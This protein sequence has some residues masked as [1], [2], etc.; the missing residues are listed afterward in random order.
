MI[1]FNE[2]IK[3]LALLLF[4]TIS[5]SCSCSKDKEIGEDDPIA[6]EEIK[7]TGVYTS[8]KTQNVNVVYFYP[9]GTT[10]LPNY[11][12]RLSGIMDYIQG[13]LADELENYGFERKEFGLQRDTGDNSL[14]KIIPIEGNETDYTNAYSKTRQEV[15]NYFDAH[16]EEESSS[17]TV[18][19][20][21]S[22]TGE[23][24]CNFNVGGALPFTGINNWGFV[25]DYKE[26]D[27]RHFRTGTTEGDCLKVGS[28][29][30]EI[31]H[32][33]NIQ[34]DRER[35]GQEWECVMSG[36]GGKISRQES[37]GKIH[38]TKT[39]CAVLDRSEVFNSDGTFYGDPD[40]NI[41]QLQV[42]T[43]DQDVIVLSAKVSSSSKVK[44]LGVFHDKAPYIINQ[45]YDAINW[46]GAINEN[47]EVRMEMPL[48]EFFPEML[49]EG[50]E[51]RMQLKFIHEDGSRTNK[52]FVYTIEAG[53]PNI[54]I[55]ITSEDVQ[56][57]D[58]S[59]WEVLS[60]S[61]D[62]SFAPKEALIDGDITTFWHSKWTDP[63]STLPQN[64]VI[65]MG[66]VMTVKGLTF[67]Q[68]QQTDAA[69]DGPLKVHVKDYEVAVS[70]DGSTWT[71]LGEY[72]LYQLVN[73]QYNIFD[74]EQSFRFLKITVNSTYEKD[75]CALAEIGAY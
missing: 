67:V 4:I 17:H 18:I 20:Q 21:P 36:G 49:I 16:P 58:K 64:F 74:T 19:F 23:S 10:P 34:H 57:F 12:K 41:E 66:A 9:K 25:V 53:K 73:K 5:L 54:D 40:L 61:S 71:Q 60:A 13:F 68:R 46:L 11:H 50:S 26:L 8:D 43:N 2:S 48:R 32:S 56:E 63:A 33:F 6:E 37:A 42:A 35:Y 15:R 70:T 29:M 3:S 39:A 24:G 30:H 45:D 75:T 51:L 38:I 44:Y 65:D 72:A 28:T 27:M 7:A 62:E 59:A 31:L 69:N 22:V 14:I 52:N 47:G 1:K 55:N